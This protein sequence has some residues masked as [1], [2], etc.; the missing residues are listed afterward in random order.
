MNDNLKEDIE[1]LI[2]EAGPEAM[3]GLYS[4][5]EDGEDIT[6]FTLRKILRRRR[7][8]RDGENLFT[9]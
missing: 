2:A 7:G 5:L 1:R 8:D 4:I 9:R 3:D 6:C